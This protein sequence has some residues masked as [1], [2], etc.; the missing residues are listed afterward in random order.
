MRFATSLLAVALLVS[1]CAERRT[2]PAAP[3]APATDGQ[4]EDQGPGDLPGATCGTVNEGNPANLPDFIAVELGSGDGVDRITFRFKP[5]PDAPAKP[6]WHFI[7]F[8][9]ELVTE[10]EGRPV[11]VDGKAFVVVSFQA[12]GTDLSG[13]VPEPV[14]TGD[15]RFTPGFGT[16]QEAV[17]LGDFEAQVSWGLGLS[18]KACYRVD[19]GPD[20]LTVEFPSA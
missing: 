13:E 2:E 6:P 12:I 3:P 15:Q 11:E 9:E 20:H 1:A 7:D 16:L 8:T 18:E 14:Y 10:G 5:Q 19:A 17:M 4:A